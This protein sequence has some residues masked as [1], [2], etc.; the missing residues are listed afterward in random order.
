MTQTL[1]LISTTG[2][3]MHILN[4]NAYLQIHIII[5]NMHYCGPF[6]GEYAL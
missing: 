2:I 6:S 4:T 1:I 5:E 3:I